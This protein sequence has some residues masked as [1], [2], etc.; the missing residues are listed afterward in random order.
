MPVL[1]RRMQQV[2]PVFLM[3]SA[4][5]SVIKSIASFHD[6][7]TNLPVFF[8]KGIFCPVGYVKDWRQ[9]ISFNAEESLIPV[10]F[11]AFYC[12]RLTLFV[13]PN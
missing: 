2:H 5:F 13:T 8:N 6:I 9:T 12:L 11:L 4:N 1:N 7:R 10:I 3:E